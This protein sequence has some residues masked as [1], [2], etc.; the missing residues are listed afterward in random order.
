MEF[1]IVFLGQPLGFVETN[2]RK[3]R[4]G[5]TRPVTSADLHDKVRYNSHHQNNGG[6][7]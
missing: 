6:D 3:I 2:T 1:Q 4:Y 5:T 7:T